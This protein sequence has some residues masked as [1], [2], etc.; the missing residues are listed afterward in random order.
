VVE[1]TN[2]ASEAP[3]LTS[4]PTTLSRY[5]SS[6]VESFFVTTADHNYLVA[7]WAFQHELFRDFYWNAMHALEKYLKASL[8][9]NGYSA[10]RYGHDI[11][12]LFEHVV[13]YAG[14][15]I[16]SLL[17]RPN[18]LEE[19]LWKTESTTEYLKRLFQNGDPNNR[20]AYFSYVQKPEDLFKLD[21]MVFILRRLTVSLEVRVVV[22]SL[23]P[24]RRIFR[25]H[26]QVCPEF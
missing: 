20:Y 16:P 4:F 11:T 5:Q 6:I 12:K 22:P 14:D 1:T 8:L 23:H 18:F 24:D 7:R 25:K 26:L 21:A 10:K 2:Q 15:L 19:N 3:K 13:E 9:L 17:L